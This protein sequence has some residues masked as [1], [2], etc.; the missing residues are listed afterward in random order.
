MTK[1]MRCYAQLLSSAVDSVMTLFSET[2]HKE[3]VIVIS[4]VILFS[5]DLL[6]IT[7]VELHGDC[8][9]DIS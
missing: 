3:L 7:F 6:K 4:A 2:F 9:E 1:C 5:N 8:N